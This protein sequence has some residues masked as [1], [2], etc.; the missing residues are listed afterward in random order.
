MNAVFDVATQICLERKWVKADLHKADFRML[1][2]GH[3][4][5]CSLLTYTYTSSFTQHP[6]PITRCLFVGDLSN[7]ATRPQKSPRKFSISNPEPNTHNPFTYT[8]TYTYTFTRSPV[9]TRPRK[10]PRKFYISNP[11]FIYNNHGSF[12]YNF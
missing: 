2:H 3:S 7:V 12:P 9:E 6:K 10:S 8:Y 11:F 4:P 5:S 1:R